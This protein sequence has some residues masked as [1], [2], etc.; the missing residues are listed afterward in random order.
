MKQTN[1]ALKYLL[2]QYRAIFK[3]AYFKGIV[4]AVLL[5]AGLAA[6][7]A[8]AVVSNIDTINNSEDESLRSMATLL[9]ATTSYS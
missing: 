6:G 1:N 5:T 9:T 7:Q 4:P 8:Q 2:A 3:N